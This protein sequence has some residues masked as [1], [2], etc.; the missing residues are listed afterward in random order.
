MYSCCWEHTRALFGAGLSCPDW[1]TCY[2]TWVPFLHPE[3]VANSPYSAWQIFAEWAQGGLAMIVGF[4]ILLTA[5]TALK[6]QREHRVIVW[7]ATLA[8]ALLPVQVI[9]GRLT[10]TA[11]LEPVIVTSHLGIAT[12]IVLSLM[13][14]TVATWFRAKNELGEAV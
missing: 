13:T 3:I 10:V 9:L 2:G 12:L 8:L 6:T 4:L 5:I 7:S 11:L 14:T 1:P